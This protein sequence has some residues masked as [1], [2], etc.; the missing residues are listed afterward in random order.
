MCSGFLHRFSTGAITLGVMG[1]CLFTTPRAF[2]QPAVDFKT[3]VV[4]N[5]LDDPQEVAIGNFLGGDDYPD[6]AVANKATHT[7]DWSIT[8]YQNTQDWSPVSDGLTEI[9]DSPFLLNQAPTRIELAD[10]GEASDD[11][12]PDG[13]LDIVVLMPY[14]VYGSDPQVAILYQ[15]AGGSFSSPHYVALDGDTTDAMGLALNDLDRD[16]RVV[17]ALAA[18]HTSGLCYTQSPDFGH[19]GIAVYVGNNDAT[20]DEPPYYFCTRDPT[21]NSSPKP[22]FVAIDDMDQDGLK[23][24]VCSNTDDDQIAVLINESPAP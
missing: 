6:V 9:D 21:N 5:T 23:D 24:V 19:G 8:V 11:P 12:A 2:A 22:C 18:M 10:M 14:D 13:K 7:E 16:G 20:F 4:F 17:I 1:A 15:T 3:P